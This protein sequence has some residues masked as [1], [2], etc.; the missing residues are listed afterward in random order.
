MRGDSISRYVGIEVQ[1]EARILVRQVV[2]D[3][4]VEAMAE[5]VG[6]WGHATAFAS[7]PCLAEFDNLSHF[8]LEIIR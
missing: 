2:G 3:V 6:D 4:L 8:I 7:R 1:A 5:P